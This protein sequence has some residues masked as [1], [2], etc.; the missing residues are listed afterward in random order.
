MRPS[1]RWFPDSLT[2]QAAWMRNFATEFA[3]QGAA[4]GFSPAEIATVEADAETLAWLAQNQVDIESFRR[5]AASY[6]RHVLSGRPGSPLSDF[7]QPSSLTPPPGTSVGVYRR[8]AEVVERI[9]VSPNFSAENEASLGIR[10]IR[11]ESADLNDAKPN[12]SLTAEPGNIVS[13][14]FK[15][16]KFTGIDVQMQLDTEKEWRPA[17]RFV[18]SPAELHIP[19][20]PENL[21]RLVRIRARYLDGNDAVGQYSDIDTISTIP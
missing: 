2:D 9:R 14:R 16:G 6:R 4:L 18:R 11:G 13:V 7:P 8:I 3:K 15:R 20:G 5:A 19:A 21:P 1:N 10:P 17:G 12:P